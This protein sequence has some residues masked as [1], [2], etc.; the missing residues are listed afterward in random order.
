MLTT[1]SYLFICIHQGR[2][3]CKKKFEFILIKIIIYL[4]P[5]RILAINAF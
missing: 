3:Y 4:K 1:S 2:K 5:C